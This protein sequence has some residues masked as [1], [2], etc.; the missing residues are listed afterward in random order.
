MTNA[1][2]NMAPPFLQTEHATSASA[3]GH[4]EPSRTIGL[5][6]TLTPRDAQATQETA[7][8]TVYRTHVSPTRP[9]VRKCTA[10]M[11]V[12]SMRVRD[13]QRRLPVS[14]SICSAAMVTHIP[15]VAQG[16]PLASRYHRHPCVRVI[17][18]RPKPLPSPSLPHRCPV[19]RDRGLL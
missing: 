3:Q 17:R 8:Q 12:L 1:A 19:T 14:L 6:R 7:S 4:R 5:E 11:P 15:A 9:F 16:L 10:L 13:R 18:V 2:S